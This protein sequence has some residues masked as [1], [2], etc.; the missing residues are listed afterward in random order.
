LNFRVPEWSGNFTAKVGGKTWKGKKGE[1]LTIERLWNPGDR[2]SISFD[3][4][5][6]I[7]PGGR[8]YPNSVA[9]KRGPQVLAWD[10]SLNPGIRLSQI[11]ATKQNFIKPAMFT[12]PKE[13]E[14]KEAYSVPV[15]VNNK[16]KTMVLVP[17]AEAG[18]GSGNV[19]VWL[20]R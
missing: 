16:A 20:N 3:M 10:Q 1:L 18:Q 8:S 17:F 5:L 11:S 7:L 19:A 14:W 12:L 4:P 2:V 6:Q 13:W 9:I 15:M